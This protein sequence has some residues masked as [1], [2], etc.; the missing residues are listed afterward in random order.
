MFAFFRDVNSACCQVIHENHVIYGDGVED[1]RLEAKA[2]NTKKSEA[3]A[4]DSSSE[5]RPSRCQGRNA[6][7]QGHR[8]KCSPK[9]KIFK[10][11]FQ[12]I[13]K[14]G[15]Q[16]RSSQIFCEVSGVFL[17]NFK[18]E[19]IPTIIGTDANAHHIILGSSNI[20]SRRGSVGVLC[21]CRP[22][23]L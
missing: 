9:K 1:T 8:R 14:R 6:R 5:D 21:K 23:F 16:K 13:F 10:I 12:A 2:K 7:G 3:K 20:N 11:F 4:K 18:N 19:Q 22:E 17:H 15:K